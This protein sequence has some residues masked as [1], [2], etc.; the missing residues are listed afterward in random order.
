MFVKAVSTQLTVESTYLERIVERGA[1][2]NLWACLVNLMNCADVCLLLNFCGGRGFDREASVRRIQF[3]YEPTYIVV[4]KLWV[5]GINGW[6]LAFVIPLVKKNKLHKGGGRKCMKRQFISER[7]SA[8][9]EMKKD[10]KSFLR[11]RGDSEARGKLSNQS[12][13]MRNV[14]VAVARQKF[15]FIYTYSV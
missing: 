12:Q 1:W 3:I 8:G 4:I 11:S 2:M 7:K 15:I 6:E 14:P 9:G 13:S 10:P 5:G